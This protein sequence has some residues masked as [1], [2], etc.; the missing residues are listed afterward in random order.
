MGGTG[1]SRWRGYK[2]RICVEECQVININ[3]IQPDVNYVYKHGSYNLGS[4][5]DKYWSILNQMVF[6]KI[7]VNEGKVLIEISY[8]LNPNPHDYNYI[9]SLENITLRNGGLRWYFVCPKCMGKNKYGQR[10]TK[11]FMPVNSEYFG[12]RQCHNLTYKLSQG[13]WKDFRMEFRALRREMG[14]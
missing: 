8:T 11:L 3:R 14:I 1:S 7:F 12:C 4:F 10:V 9:I 5:N 13:R 2:R 6:W